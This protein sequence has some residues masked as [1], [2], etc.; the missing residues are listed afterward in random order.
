[1]CLSGGANRF[2]DF[3]DTISGN[4]RTRPHILV[5]GG[6]VVVSGTGDIEGAAAS[7]FAIAPTTTELT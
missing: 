1:M 3:G 5:G 4:E 6:V 7:P 2:V